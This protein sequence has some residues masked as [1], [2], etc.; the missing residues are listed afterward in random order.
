MRAKTAKNGRS[1]EEIRQKFGCKAEICVDF[2]GLPLM[3]KLALFTA[4]AAG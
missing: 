2:T 1:F 3:L 4:S